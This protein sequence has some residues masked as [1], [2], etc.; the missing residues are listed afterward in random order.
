MLGGLVVPPVAMVTLPVRNV[1]LRHQTGSSFP[2]CP[3]EAW[4]LERAAMPQASTTSTPAP[5]GAQHSPG[6]G[7]CSPLFT[8]C[9]RPTALSPRAGWLHWGS[10]H[11]HPLP[12]TYKIL[13]TCW[14]LRQ[15]CSPPARHV[16]RAAS[17]PAPTSIL[18]GA[19]S[20]KQP[21]IR[22]RQRQDLTC[23]SSE[24]KIPS[25]G[26][27]GRCGQGSTG[28]P[29]RGERGTG[30]DQRDSLLLPGGMQGWGAGRQEAVQG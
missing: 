11:L 28:S 23:A 7:C 17:P 10:A 18:G 25:H 22:E 29:W 5:M 3:S 19:Q 21:P 2:C 20:P 8:P 15:G 30:G 4:A 1:H 26:C 27:T 13:P 24:R 9:A 6:K 12:G 14:K 16:P